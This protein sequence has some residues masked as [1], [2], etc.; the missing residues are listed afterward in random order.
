MVEVGDLDGVVIEAS[1][2]EGEV[3]LADQDEVAGEGALPVDVAGAVHGRDVAVVGP[4][5]V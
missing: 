1:T 3:A 2:A 4:E 5:G